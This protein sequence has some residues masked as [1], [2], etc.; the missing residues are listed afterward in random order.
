MPAAAVSLTLI[1]FEAIGKKAARD[2]PYPPR[3]VGSSSRVPEIPEPSQGVTCIRRGIKGI[4][5]L[6]GR[7][8]KEGFFFSEEKKQKTFIS[9]PLPRLAAMAG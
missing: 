5:C 3:R 4:Q 2:S 9:S 1:Q 8:D 6:E 7:Q